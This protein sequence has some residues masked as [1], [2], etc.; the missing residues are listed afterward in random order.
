MIR[1]A[2]LLLA[3]LA[4]G[5]ARACAPA[6]P[7]TAQDRPI[8]VWSDGSFTDAA[9]NDDGGTFSGRPVVDIGGG[10]VGQRLVA[11]GCLT[12]EILLFVDCTAGEAIAVHG[13]PD[14]RAEPSGLLE[15]TRML[16][17]PLGPLALRPTTTVGALRALGQE[18]GWSLIEDVGGFA[19]NRGRR[20][21]FDPFMGCR[22]LYPDQ[23]GAAS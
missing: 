4:P 19:A 15:S 23:P 7:A 3:L 1:P 14:L 10:R 11:T 20:N 16:Q 22:I 8:T 6:D 12:H 13:R 9:E 5:A 2:L 21:A 18:Q 17:Q